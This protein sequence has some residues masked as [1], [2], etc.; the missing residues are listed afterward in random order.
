MA[1]LSFRGRKYAPVR[2]F[3]LLRRS[4]ILYGLNETKHTRRLCN[5]LHQPM[6][7]DGRHAERRTDRVF[8][9]FHCEIYSQLSSH[10]RPAKK[11][12]FYY[13]KSTRI[14]HC[15]SIMLPMCTKNRLQRVSDM[16]LQACLAR[17]ACRHISI[18]RAHS[19]RIFSTSS[20][21]NLMLAHFVSQFLSL[22]K[23]TDRHLYCSLLVINGIDD[24][25]LSEIYK[26]AADTR[27]Q[28]IG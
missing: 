22:Q 12:C 1:D 15:D 10:Y 6:A 9:K 27:L 3:S 17:Y 24:G 8:D 14:E 13:G 20:Y 25:I 2:P 11:I 23:S 26:F 18:N 16:L 5:Q 28:S 19:Q 21:Q 7:R 4:R